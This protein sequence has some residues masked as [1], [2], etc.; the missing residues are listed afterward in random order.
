MQ[1]LASQEDL[2]AGRITERQLERRLKR[3]GYVRGEKIQHH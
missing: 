1:L 2:L 3:M